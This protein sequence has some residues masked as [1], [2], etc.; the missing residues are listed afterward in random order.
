MFTSD[1]AM[2][3][4]GLLKLPE[5]KQKF[6]HEEGERGLIPVAKMTCVRILQCRLS[7]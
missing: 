7:G 1:V 5:G 3:K 6:R 4:R 2:K